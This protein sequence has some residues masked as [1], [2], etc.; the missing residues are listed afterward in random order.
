MGKV[1]GMVRILAK[2]SP[3]I[4]SFVWVGSQNLLGELTYNIEEKAKYE[5]VL[6]QKVEQV[7]QEMLGP[8]RA[9]VV[10]NLDMDLSQKE[11]YKMDSSSATQAYE[12]YAWA[13]QDDQL[14]FMP[15]FPIPSMDR[16]SAPKTHAP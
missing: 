2:V 15:G 9:K 1:I 12:K 6:E 10:I 7:L 4:L 13:N 5:K 8:G 16:A 11:K 3:L 14:Y